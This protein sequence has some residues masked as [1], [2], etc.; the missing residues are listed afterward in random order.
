[1]KAT[2][3]TILTMCLA[4]AQAQD[5]EKNPS[6]PWVNKICLNKQAKISKIDGMITSVEILSNTQN[7]FSIN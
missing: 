2:R 1:M 3:K 4:V 5:I 7:P 6:D